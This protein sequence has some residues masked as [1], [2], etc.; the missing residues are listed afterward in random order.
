[1]KG[2][3]FARSYREEEESCFSSSAVGVE[4]HYN[5]RHRFSTSLSLPLWMLEVPLSPP[6]FP[7]LLWMLITGLPLQKEE[8]GVDSLEAPEG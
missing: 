5:W 8:K 4:V 2:G 1:M 3:P 6:S 7:P